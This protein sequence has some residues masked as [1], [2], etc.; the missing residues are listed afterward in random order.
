[1]RPLTWQPLS[2]PTPIFAMVVVA[3]F[4]A[5]CDAG[6]G[7]SAS[8]TQP[9]AGARPRA[10]VAA[11]TSR[12]AEVGDLPAPGTG[13]TDDAKSATAITGDPVIAAAGDIACSPQETARTLS[14]TRCVM[15]ATSDLLIEAPLQGVLELGDAQY[16]TGRIGDFRRVYG[17][18]WGRL[19]SI[20]HPTAGNHEYLTPNAAG[21]FKYFGSRAGRPSRGYYSFD[22]GAWHLI[23]LNSNC[24]KVGGCEATSP[25]GRWLAHDLSTHRNRC[26]LAFWHHPRFSSGSNGSQVGTAPFWNQL[27]AAGADVVLAGHDHEYERFVPLTPAGRPDK[28]R[29]IREFVVGTGGSHLDP[30]RQ[31]RRGSA[32][33]SDDA[34]G[35]LMLTL[36]PRR[37]EWRFVPLMDLASNGFTDAGTGT[38]H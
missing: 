22:I 2:S 15:Q 6:G 5:G 18:S 27:Y 7:K 30:F 34:F 19:R 1:M 28:R 21:Y 11:T 23:S 36:H 26:T 25:Q 12:A 9:G 32:V 16:E 38:C 35:V 20:T 17:T 8:V 14:P 10:T 13:T 29:G 33:R 3:M 4:T 31:A 24:S 37:Y